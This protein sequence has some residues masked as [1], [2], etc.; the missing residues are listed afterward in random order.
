MTIC[1][2]WAGRWFVFR[3]EQWLCTGKGYHTVLAK[4]NGVGREVHFLAFSLTKCSVDGVPPP[5]PPPKPHDDLSAAVSALTARLDRLPCGAKPVI[6]DIFAY[7]K[8]R[9]HAQTS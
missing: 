3:G 6:E 5:V 7:P 9:Q 2:F 4:C 8:Q 1:D